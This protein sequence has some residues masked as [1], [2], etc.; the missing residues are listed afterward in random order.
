ML[1]NLLNTEEN[2][3]VRESVIKSLGKLGGEEATSTLES[4]WF[5]KEKSRFGKA[6]ARNALKELGLW[7]GKKPI[8]NPS[9]IR[10][11][12]ISLRAHRDEQDTKR[13][14]G[15]QEL[16]D[17]I[18]GQMRAIILDAG[19]SLSQIEDL[20]TSLKSEF[21]TLMWNISK[22]KQQWYYRIHYSMEIKD[23]E[24]TNSLM[25][26]SPTSSDEI[27]ITT[28]DTLSIES[29][30]KRA[31]REG[32]TID[33]I[34]ENRIRVIG[35]QWPGRI[36]YEFLNLSLDLMKTQCGTT[37]IV[38]GF[39]YDVCDNWFSCIRLIIRLSRWLGMNK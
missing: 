17:E 27:I 13:D 30:A 11:I 23:I 35:S 5:G 16:L 7:E 8:L 39:P 24:V 38:D 21:F 9:A 28:R 12:F 33:L 19:Y 31:R 20:G 29:A 25:P 37:I 2:E 18:R 26:W 3:N 15:K 4:V 22:L 6:A 1:R 34:L 14:R 32:L 36:D 10:N